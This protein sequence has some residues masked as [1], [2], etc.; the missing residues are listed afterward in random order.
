MKWLEPAHP[1]S[2]VSAKA[3]VM[4][5]RHSLER[6]GLTVLVEAYKGFAPFGQF[7]EQEFRYRGVSL[8]FDF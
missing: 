7:F 3:G 4:I 6:R 2:A 5:G 1:H 8:Q